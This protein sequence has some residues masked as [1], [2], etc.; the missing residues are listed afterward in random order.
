MEHELK[1]GDLVEV[2]LLVR[3]ENDPRKG[4][5]RGV[6]PEWD[7]VFGYDFWA[8]VT[9]FTRGTAAYKDPG[10][11]LENVVARPAGGD[12]V[13]SGPAGV[14]AMLEEALVEDLSDTDTDTDT[15]TET[16]S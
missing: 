13:V 9:R 15:D 12:V 3:L 1:G 16:T 7:R 5:P 11:V 2:T 4:M 14:D 8:R 6:E 10:M